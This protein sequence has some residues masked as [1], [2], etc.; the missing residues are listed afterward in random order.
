MLKLCCWKATDG[1]AEIVPN[2]QIII[3]N[4]HTYLLYYS[5]EHEVQVQSTAVHSMN[6]DTGLSK[7]VIKRACLSTG[8]V[9]TN[10][11]R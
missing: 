2:I 10:Y 11:T 6:T 4:D 3:P 1:E 9:S 8:A 7:R 5:L